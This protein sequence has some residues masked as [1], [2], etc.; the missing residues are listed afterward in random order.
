MSHGPGFFC[1]SNGPHRCA[2]HTDS[3]DTFTDGE[4][5]RPLCGRCFA[6]LDDD[7]LGSGY[8]GRCGELYDVEAA[9]AETYR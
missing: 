6:P 9:I 5:G 3:R 8:C 2:C 1:I 4:V 7:A